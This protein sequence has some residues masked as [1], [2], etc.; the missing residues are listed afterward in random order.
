MNPKS[1]RYNYI[2]PWACLQN[3]VS[4]A[5]YLRRVMS[6][7]TH[8]PRSGRRRKKNKKSQKKFKTFL[9]L[10]KSLFSATDDLMWPFRVTKGRTDRAIRFATHDLL[11]VFYRNYSA[12]SQRNPVFQQMTLIWPFKVTKGQIDYDI[13]FATHDLLLVFYRNYS[14]ISHRIPV[15]Q[16]M[17]LI[18]PFRV[19][20]G[21]TDYDIRFATYHSIRVL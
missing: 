11:L 7:R 17:T 13:R 18:W 12:I 21:Q 2:Y 16:Q 9:L 6:R 19:T 20:K 4:I 14:A 3:F 10:S 1:V 5:Q 8:S 15:F